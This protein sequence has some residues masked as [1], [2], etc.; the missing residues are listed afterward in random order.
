MYISW[1]NKQKK[2]KGIITPSIS[3]V[4]NGK[5]NLIVICLYENH[6]PIPQEV[7][8]NINI[9]IKMEQ[10]KQTVVQLVMSPHI[11]NTRESTLDFAW[12]EFYQS[13]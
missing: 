2:L 4:L 11:H 7:K 8:K 6:H 1:Q 5:N 9:Q 13:I 12:S 10:S 3:N